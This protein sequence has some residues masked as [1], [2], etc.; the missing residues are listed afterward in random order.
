[1]FCLICPE[2]K[3]RKTRQEWAGICGV[4][5]NLP[6]DDIEYLY[7]IQEESPA[8]VVIAPIKLRTSQLASRRR[9]EEA[10]RYIPSGARVL[11]IGCATSLALEFVTPCQ[12][13]VAFDLALSELRHSKRI[14]PRLKVL[15]ADASHI[16]FRS[17]S[18]DTVMAMDV[19]EH[20][21][22]AKMLDVL[23]D[24]A[25][26]LTTGGQLILS[27]PSGEMTWAKRFLGRRVHESHVVEYTQDEI[28]R[29]LHDTGFRNLTFE[30]MHFPHFPYSFVGRVAQNV[31][32]EFPWMM[33]GA[34][35][36]TRRL[37]YYNYLCRCTRA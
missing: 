16:P 7:W 3:R 37:G 26:V 31:V 35:H 19:I 30:E 36:V 25:R 2:A 15:Q 8:N 18:F 5:K 33:N 27:T 13:Y 1:M 4:C 29:H 21:P 23:K 24:L 14:H 11:E 34:A 17:A 10:W 28:G 12:Q 22:T 20:M 6:L 9:Y 32:P